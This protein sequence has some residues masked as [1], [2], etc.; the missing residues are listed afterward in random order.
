MV[1]Q[2]P[3]VY[4][5]ALYGHPSQDNL[6]AHHRSFAPEW[7]RSITE[8]EAAAEKAKQHAAKY[9]NN[10]AHRLP[11]IQVGSNV[12]LQDPRTKLWDTYGI[13][14]HVGPHRQYHIR[15]QPGSTLIRNH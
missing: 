2:R 12:V 3:T 9:Y 6:P 7:Q 10:T 8:A 11:D 1:R 14:T 13:V 15:T 5:Q 4:S